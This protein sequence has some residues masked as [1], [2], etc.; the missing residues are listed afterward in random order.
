MTT[1]G[2]IELDRTVDSLRVGRRHRADLGDIDA[3]AASIV[4]ALSE[5]PQSCSPNFPR[6]R[7]Q[8]SAGLC[9]W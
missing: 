1:P 2:H 3:L 5:S 8:V 9:R 7:G 6:S 4:T